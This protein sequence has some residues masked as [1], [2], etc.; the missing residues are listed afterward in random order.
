MP[1]H[2]FTFVPH[3]ITGTTNEVCRKYLEEMGQPLPVEN[4]RAVLQEYIAEICDAL[5]PADRFTA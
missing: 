1:N 2:R 3:P 4:D 5:D